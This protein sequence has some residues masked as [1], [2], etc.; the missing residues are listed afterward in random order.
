MAESVKSVSGLHKKPH[1]GAKRLR[2]LALAVVIVLVAAYLFYSMQGATV[3]SSPETVTITGV[4]SYFRIGGSVYGIS[5]ASKY[6]SAA[7]VYVSKLPAFLNPLL[8]VT[9]YSGNMTKLGMGS[10]FANLGLTL[11]SLGNSSVTVR[12][13]PLDVNLQLAPDSGKVSVVSGLLAPR[14]AGSNTVVAIT[15]VATSTTVA[16]TTTVTQT[17]STLAGI[18]S[19]LKKNEYY[20]LMLNYTALYA[21]TQNCTVNAYNT[22]FIKVNGNMPSGPNTYQNISVYVPY[23]MYSNL[24][25]IGNGNYLMSFSTKTVDP[26]YNNSKAVVIK[27]NAPTSAV[28][29][30]T[31]ENMFKGENYTTLYIGYNK[32]L[33]IGGACGIIVP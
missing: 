19:A 11:E 10:G 3:I 26:T 30:V 27:V 5:L 9:L 14:T 4:T 12:I 28:I 24:T 16:S 18:M 2:I 15:T 21:N 31:L 22:A 7:Y 17:N 6:P 1:R 20:G 23:K 8:D 29:N 33:G 25:S 13:T 32:A